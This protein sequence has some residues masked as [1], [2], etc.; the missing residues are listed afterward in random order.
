MRTMIML[1]L[2]VVGCSSAQT[3]RIVPDAPDRQLSPLAK[4]ICRR[5]Q[6]VKSWKEGKTTSGIDESGLH[7]WYVTTHF[8]DGKVE[9]WKCRERWSTGYGFHVNGKPLCLFLDV[10]ENEYM[11]G[12]AKALFLRLDQEISE[13]RRQKEGKI[14]DEKR[15]READGVLREILK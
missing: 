2:G 15:Q 13:P 9:V 6:K 4:E 14:A 3:P 10:A 11:R 7:N 1:L 5:A 8:T 12:V